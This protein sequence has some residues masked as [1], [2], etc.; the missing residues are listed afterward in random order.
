M[1]YRIVCTDT[2]EVVSTH[3]LDQCAQDRLC[4]DMDRY[5]AAMMESEDGKNWTLSELL[6][7]EAE[8][9]FVARTPRELEDRVPPTVLA[10]V[11]DQRGILKGSFVRGKYTPQGHRC[12]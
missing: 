7:V 10:R 1:L 11:T 12:R 5:K 8:G 9:C 4:R 6:V 2:D 3:R